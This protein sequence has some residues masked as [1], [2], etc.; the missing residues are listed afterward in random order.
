MRILVFFDLPVV[1][2]EDRKEQKEFA[3]QLKKQ[4]ENENY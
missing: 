4:M 1:E 3:K 2:K